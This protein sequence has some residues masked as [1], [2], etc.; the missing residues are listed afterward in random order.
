[1]PGICLTGK[2]YLLTVSGSTSTIPP[3]ATADKKYP[4]ILSCHAGS[5]T[6]GSKEGQV[7]IADAMSEW[8]FAVVAID[9]RVGYDNN[10][11]PCA[12]DTLGLNM[13]TYRA[14]Q[15]GNACLRFLYNYADSFHI[16]TT[17][18]FMM[19]NSAG[20][21]LILH[22]Q[23]VTDAVAKIKIAVCLQFI[24]QPARYR[25]Y[26]SLQLQNQRDLCHVGRLAQLEPGQFKNGSADHPVQGRTRSRVCPT[27]PVFT[28]TAPTTPTSLPGMAFTNPPSLPGN[29]VS[30]TTSA[31]AFTQHTMM[32]FAP[33]P[34]ILFSK[35][36]CATSLTPVNTFTISQA[37]NNTL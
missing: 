36:C 33:K 3:G 26:V 2:T 12:D 28:K 18:F 8:G 13:A 24:G 35:P 23:Y 22:M 1:M 7:S 30:I 14:T 20:A 10:T 19:G 5:F 11:D 6:G 17:Q 34:P 29:H 27:L 15:D 31:W 16:D 9:Y 21:D 32:N 25:Q 37:G 4:L